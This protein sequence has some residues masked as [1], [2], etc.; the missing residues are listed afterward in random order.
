MEIAPN[1]R[2]IAPSAA[3]L[4]AKSLQI[5]LR[6]VLDIANIGLNP[7]CLVSHMETFPQTLPSKGAK[8]EYW[9]KFHKLTEIYF[10]VVHPPYELVDITNHL[11]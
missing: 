3:L 1:R 7:G 5:C 2:Q 10:F 9:W 8:L 6:R 11:S 4:F